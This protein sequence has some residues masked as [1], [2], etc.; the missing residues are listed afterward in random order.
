MVDE[1]DIDGWV[2]V[3]GDTEYDIDGVVERDAEA[4]EGGTGIHNPLNRPFTGPLGGP[5]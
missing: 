2:E 3:D 1:Q 4:E 5:L